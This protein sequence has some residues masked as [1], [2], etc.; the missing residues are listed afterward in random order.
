[1]FFIVGAAVLSRV[2]VAEGQKAARDA[3]ADLRPAPAA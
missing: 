1:V 2:D 3:E